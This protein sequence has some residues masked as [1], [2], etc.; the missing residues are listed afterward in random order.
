MLGSM[1]SCIGFHGLRP[2]LLVVWFVLMGTTPRSFAN[3][4]P[5]FSSTQTTQLV[6]VAATSDTIGS[7]GFLFSCS[8]DKLFTGGVGL[9]N[10][11]GRAIRVPWPAGLE[12]QAIT[13][14]P[15]RGGARM[16]IR[17][18][19]GLPFALS[20]LRFKL[21][22]N[23]AGAGAALEVMPLL[24]G[25]DGVPDP[26]QYNATGFYGSNF[27]YTTPELTGFDT[28]ILTLYVDFAL[29]GAVMVDSRIPPPVLGIAALDATVLELSWP[30]E[31]ADYQLES[32]VT[33]PS[34][35]WTP[36]TNEVLRVGDVLIA[37]VASPGGGRQYFRLKK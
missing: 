25:E 28:Y 11:V 26:F 19:D 35:V 7:E 6:A 27:S 16:V 24:D 34:A 18:T 36:V 4:I 1:T 33:L 8:R 12:A 10:A 29:T 13:T 37:Q 15:N 20:S 2:A 30:A 3:T 17:S 23:T 31:A 14:G 22:A 32:S 21:L 9:T 5:F